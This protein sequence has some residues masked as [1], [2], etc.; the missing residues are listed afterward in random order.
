MFEEK[1]YFCFLNKY[2]HLLFC[3]PPIHSIYCFAVEI[4][5][6]SSAHAVA[7]R[8]A[9]LNLSSKARY[10][11]ILSIAVAFQPS[12]CEQK[13]LLVQR[14]CLVSPNPVRIP[15][16]HPPRISCDQKRRSRWKLGFKKN[17]QAHALFKREGK[18]TDRQ[19]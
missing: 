2:I 13:Q 18:L 10:R 16:C 15:N 9:A 14:S 11:L 17:R 1:Y 4:Q 12:P 6:Y 3:N 7:Y 5:S 8:A 19:G